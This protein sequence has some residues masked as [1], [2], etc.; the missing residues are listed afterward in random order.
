M[1]WKVD[2]HDLLGV[3]SIAAAGGFS[4]EFPKTGPL[5]WIAPCLVIAGAAILT[6]SRVVASKERTAVTAIGKLADNSLIQ[7]VE[8]ETPLVV[9][10]LTTLSQPTDKTA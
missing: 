3:A 2:L 10:K 6:T 1:N 4:H 5:A 9:G 8:S 7:K